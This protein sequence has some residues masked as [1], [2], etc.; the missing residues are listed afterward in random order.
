MEVIRSTEFPVI[1]AIG[2]I[3]HLREPHKFFEAFQNSKADYLYACVPMFSLSVYIENIFPSVYPRNLSGGHTHLFSNES[4]EWL[5]ENF[6]LNPIAEW[7]FGS[8]VMDLARSI[9]QSLKDN[10]SSDRL[11]GTFE[12]LFENNIDALQAIIDKSNF[13]SEIHFL[14]SKG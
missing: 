8:D 6:N 9:I 12:D 4:L 2:V 14:V 3:E 10:E 5:Y 1:S 13:S 7:R 11:C